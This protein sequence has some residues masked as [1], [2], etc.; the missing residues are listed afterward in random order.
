MRKTPKQILKEV[1]TNLS[2]RN[3]PNF[4]VVQNLKS[5]IKKHPSSEELKEKLQ[6]I[7][8]DPEL[9]KS[10]PKTLYLVLVVSIG[11]LG[12]FILFSWVNGDT[13]ITGLFFGIIFII[14]SAVIFRQYKKEE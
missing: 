1:N 14:I 2:D 9:S 13:D 7:E 8:N 6:S 12:L 4:I 11:L 10:S 5:A 3:I